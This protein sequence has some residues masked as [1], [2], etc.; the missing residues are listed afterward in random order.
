MSFFDITDGV[1]GAEGSAQVTIDG[2]IHKLFD[3]KK[4]EAKFDKQKSEHRAVGSR[5]MQS[6]AKGWKGT[7]SMTLYYISAVFREAALTYMETGRDLYFDLLVTNEDPQSRLGK[8]TMLFTGCNI[9][10]TILSKIDVDAD[11]L[12]EEVAFTF[13]GAKMIEK[14]KTLDYLN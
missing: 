12:D 8:Q 9:D 6:R 14:F 7:G 1:S 3:A 10:S 11:V 13:T 4:I 5:A 2:N